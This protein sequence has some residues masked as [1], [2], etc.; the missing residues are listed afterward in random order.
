MLERVF[1]LKAHGSTAAREVIAGLTTFAAMAYIL[2]VNPLILSQTGIDKGALVTATAI[3]SAVMTIVMALATNYPIALAPGMGLNA[4]FTYTICLTKGIPWQAALGFVFYSGLIFLALTLSRLR[5]RIVEAIPFELKLAITSGI[6]F[7]I[8]LIGLEN[9]G[10]I[11]LN[12]DVVPKHGPVVPEAA[13]YLTLGD[14]GTAAP[15]LVFIGIILTGILVARRLPGSIVLVILLLTVAG[16]FIPA[17]DGSGMITKPPGTIFNL[18]SSLA[19]TFLK[20]DLGYFWQHLLTSLPLVLSILFVDLFD[21]MGTLIGVSKRAGLLDEKGN[22]P[23]V[24]RAFMADACAA[25]FGSTLGTSTVTSYIES[26]AGVEAGG[27]T[28]MTAIVTAI[29]FLLALFLT[30]LILIIP[31]VAT[32]P[33]LVVVGAFMMQG[34]AELDLRDFS[35]AAPAFMTIVMMPFAFSISEGIAFGILTYVG[36][37]LG[38]GKAKEVAALTYTLAVLF[39]LYFI[40]ER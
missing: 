28:G 33:A 25:M 16:L 15:W 21:N 31:A 32:A 30:P 17:A 35:K 3:A 6:G 26:A 34:L 9:G 5:Q 10:L 4:F 2:A 22:L 29:C 14:L 18:P 7:F 39:L 37:K 19:P 27:R 23:K 20:L 8:A 24:G 36:I 40:F 1:S 38:T 13:P 11:V 12:L